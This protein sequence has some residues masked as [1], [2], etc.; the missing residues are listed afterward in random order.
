MPK[1]ER[2]KATATAVLWQKTGEGNAATRISLDPWP[3]GTHCWTPGRL[4][5]TAAKQGQKLLIAGGGY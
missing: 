4:A 5:H 3:S 1:V 2:D